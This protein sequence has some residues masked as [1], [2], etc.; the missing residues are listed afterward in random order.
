M[1]DPELWNRV[2]SAHPDAPEADFPFSARLARENGWARDYALRVIGEY[3]RFAYLS[4]ISPSV[5][6]PSEDVDQVWHLH[7]TFTKHYWGPFKD[8]LGG[9]LH[10]MPTT[11]G[12]GQAAFFREAYETTKALYAHEFGSPPPEDVWPSA[13]N[14]FSRGASYRRVNTNDVWLVPKPNV[15]GALS[16]TFGRAWKIRK[17]LFSAVLALTSILFGSQIA[18][19]HGET[20]GDGFLEKFFNMV[21]HWITG[22]TTEM[23][24]GSVVFALV[25]FAILSERR[26]RRRRGSSKDSSSNYGGCSS[27][28]GGSGDSSGCSSC[29]GGGD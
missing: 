16:K 15:P 2:C 3:L 13:D 19:A 17:A 4:Q 14:R 26:S 10:H 9:A 20:P 23:L 22:H 25:V 5:V 12:A 18:F 1:Q 27:S 29:G 28:S 24:V 11:G 7:L 6:T 21:V 8:A